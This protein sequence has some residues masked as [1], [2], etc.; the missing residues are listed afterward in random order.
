MCILDFCFQVLGVCVFV[1][2]FRREHHLFVFLHVHAL[3]CMR[4]WLWV[5][6]AVCAPGFGLMAQANIKAVMLAH[7]F[8]QPVQHMH[9]LIAPEYIGQSASDHVFM[10]SNL[11]NI[12]SLSREA[13]ANMAYFTHIWYMPFLVDLQLAASAIH[14]QSLSQHLLISSLLVC[15]LVYICHYLLMLHRSYQLAFV[16]HCSTSGGFWF[17]HICC[18]VCKAD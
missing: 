6:L 10:A 12:I 3:D 14:L 4:V 16:G 2:G 15:A 1:T 9:M 17:K 11:L 5:L 7:C 18:E 13:Q 8:T